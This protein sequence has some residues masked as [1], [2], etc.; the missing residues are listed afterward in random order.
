MRIR[1]LRTQN[2]VNMD[3]LKKFKDVQLFNA[4]N[5]Y[6]LEH[7]IFALEKAEAAFENGEAISSNLF[8]EVMVRASGQRQIKKAI[9]LFGIEGSSEF[10]VLGEFPDNLHELLEAADFEITLDE[11]R[12]TLLKEVFAISEEELSGVETSTEHP[13]ISLINE[14]IA[15]TGVI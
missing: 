6:G 9:E 10:V 8:V 15:L 4:S 14:R 1:A 5:I 2:P 12:L 13:I 3:V 11:E 7:V